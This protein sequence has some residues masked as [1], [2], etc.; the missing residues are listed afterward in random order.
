MKKRS[1]AVSYPTIPVIYVSSARPDRIPVHNTMGMSVTDVKEETRT[2]TSV[3][4]LPKEKGFKFFINGKE[5]DEERI[6]SAEKIIKFFREKANYNGG[7]KIESANYNIYSGSS[8][9]G[10]AALAVAMNDIF[11]TNLS[12]DEIA[13]ISMMGSESS[14]RSLYGGLNEIVVDPPPK[15]YGV[16]L[17]SEEDMK[18]VRI[19]ALTFDYPS[20]FTAQEIFHAARSHPFYKHRLEMI[21]EWEAR[22]KLGLHRKDWNM[23]FDAAEE[24]IRNVNYMLEDNGVRTRR[25]EMMMAVI[26][27]EEIRKS[28]IPA[29]WVAGGGNVISVVSWGEHAEKVK[30]K[31]IE[32]GW[33][34][35]EYKIASGTRI[36][37]SE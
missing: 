28:N 6:G 2:E 37:K 20:R 32:N 26:D 30:K 23:V 1:V 22:I 13:E 12:T 7:I 36:V 15:M 9:A 35:I 8:D 17:A 33:K 25:K 31:L 4:L 29:Y 27:V 16:Q 14:I 24:N 3:E 19:F 18:D 11:E 5:I 34:P 21:H 10:F